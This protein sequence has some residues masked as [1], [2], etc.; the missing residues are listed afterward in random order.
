MAQQGSK[1]VEASAKDVARPRLS[2]NEASASSLTD[3]MGPTE[4]FGIWQLRG[5]AFAA[6]SCTVGLPSRL[7]TS[8]R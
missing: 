5:R 7:V 8:E 2:A 4:A 6:L 1:L 3:N